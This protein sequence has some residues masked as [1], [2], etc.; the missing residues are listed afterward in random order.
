M[1]LAATSISLADGIKTVGVL[2]DAARADWEDPVALSFENS[3]WLPLKTQIEATM[4]ALDRLG[5]ILDRARR[6]CS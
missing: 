6:E 1:S 2:W 3:H 5:P 4:G